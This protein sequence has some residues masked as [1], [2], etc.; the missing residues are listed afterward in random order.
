MTLDENL[1]SQDESF[2][3]HKVELSGLK[4]TAT[5]NI[6]PAPLQTNS[7]T[8]DRVIEVSNQQGEDKLTIEFAEPKIVKNHGGSVSFF[9][10]NDALIMLPQTFAAD[11]N[12]QLILTYTVNGGT[13]EKQVTTPLKDIKWEAGKSY[14]Y[15]IKLAIDKQEMKV[16]A[17]ITDW[18]VLNADNFDA[19]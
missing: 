9:D 16:K 4:T 7:Q 5:F 11:S 8:D 6:I 17:T 15:K 10:D 12:A 13:Q 19:Y 3:F 1:M 14:A 2:Q 18:E